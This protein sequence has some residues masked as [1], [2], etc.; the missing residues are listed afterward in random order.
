M[1][2]LITP[3][4]S[5]PL[6]RMSHAGAA[7]PTT[8]VGQMNPG[9]LTC[10]IA[11]TSGWPTGGAAGPFLIVIDAGS[12]SEEKILCSAQTGGN[13]TVASGGRGF[14][15]TAQYLHSAGAP[16]EH[17]AGAC[18]LDD[19]N[20]HIYDTSRDDPSHSKY[21]LV[22]GARPFTGLQA[23][24]AGLNATGPVGLTGPVTV[25]GNETVS[26]TLS[27]GSTATAQALVAT[28]SGANGRFVGGGV[29]GPPTG[30]PYNVG[31]FIVNQDGTVY[32]CI[33][34]GSP[35]TWKSPPKGYIA[36][37]QGPSVQTDCSS[38][39]TNLIAI[40]FPVINGRRYRV[41]PTANASQ[42]TA[43]GSPRAYLGS[44]TGPIALDPPGNIYVF[45]WPTTPNT[46]WNIYQQTHLYFTASGNGTATMQLQASTTA[47][48]LRFGAN[49]SQVVVEDI[50]TT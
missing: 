4:V 16:V 6:Q 32:I 2:D 44:I 42:I 27:A 7:V 23:F 9:D 37:F 21:P 30:G 45:F 26:G 47:G 40:S 34:A 41:V 17:V 39:T 33:T 28:L 8:L 25:T 49:G 48:A 12:G 3:L 43:V 5:A 24:N 11:G 31:D 36:E 35:G 10:V 13:I 1:T 50:G 38:A 14:D 19:A 46:G 22:S 18:E 29:S 15:N 20:A